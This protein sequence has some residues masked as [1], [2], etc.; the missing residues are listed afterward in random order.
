MLDEV[1]IDVER[2]RMEQLNKKIKLQVGMEFKSIK[3]FKEA[4]TEWN[5]LNGWELKFVKNNK[6]GCI[7]ICRNDCAFIALCSQIGEAHTYRIKTWYRD[8]T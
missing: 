4:I 8:R 1:E 2:F 3:E 5:A 7:V 6:I